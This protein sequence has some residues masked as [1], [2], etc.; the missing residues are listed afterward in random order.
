MLRMEARETGA[1]KEAKDKLEKQV[2]DLKSC[3]QLEKRQRADLE[4]EKG[5]EIAKL[6]ESLQA[7]QSKFDET[8]ALLVKERE[9]AQK[10]GE[11]VQRESDEASATV[12][13][14]PGKECENVQRESEEATATVK[15][16]PGNERENLQR[17]GEE[18][19]AIVKETLEKERKNAQRESEEASATIKETP[20][21]GREN[22]Q[23]ESVEASSTV[24]ETPRNERENVQKKCE[25]ASSTVKETPIPVEDS[26]RVQELSAEVETLK[27][28]RQSDK[29]RADEFERKYHEAVQS[30]EAKSQ[31]LQETEVKIHQLQESLNSVPQD[32]IQHV[33]SS[34][35]AEND[36][37]FLIQFEF[38]F[39]TLTQRQS[40]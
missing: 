18:A 23:R 14:T 22:A 3:L 12:K 37:A 16:T 9:N 6:Q 25:E 19:Y 10:E 40:R 1:L 5:Q 28:S 33:Q 31:K 8:N 38:N 13:E 7:L 17:K 11:N 35:R 36:S 34:F 26:K 24:K 4:E 2:E 20:E 15:E 29:D 30:S 32:D 27:A 21:K 39:R